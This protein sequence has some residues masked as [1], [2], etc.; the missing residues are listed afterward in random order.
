MFIHTIVFLGRFR[1]S[2]NF[3]NFDAPQRVSLK[4]AVSLIFLLNR[5]AFLGTRL[6]GNILKVKFPLSHIF[7]LQDSQ[8]DVIL[9]E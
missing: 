3:W 4:F 6:A 8:L 7:C 9:T 2:K 5:W 1:F